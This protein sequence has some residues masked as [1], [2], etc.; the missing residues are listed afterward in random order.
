M[1]QTLPKQER[2]HSRKE[3]DELF[4]NSL[5]TFVYPFKI[6]YKA[7]PDASNSEAVIL[8]TM[9]HKKFKHAVQRNAIKRQLRECYRTQKNDLTNLLKTNNLNAKIA[10]IYVADSL[11]AHQDIAIKMKV[12]LQRICK[13]IEKENQQKTVVSNSTI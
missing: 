9:S 1:R 13:L 11:I 6:L 3:I 5:S 2:L 7:V 10:F 12:A 8:F 4:Q